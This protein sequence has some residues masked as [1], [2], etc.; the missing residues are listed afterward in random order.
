MTTSTDSP[1][2][3][4][5]VA[6]NHS[7]IQVI[8]HQGSSLN[9]LSLEEATPTQTGWHRLSLSLN[10]TVLEL[11][12][13]GNILFHTLQTEMSYTSIHLGGPDS[14]LSSQLS[15]LPFHDYFIGC[16]TNVTINNND[17]TFDS[18]QQRGVQSGCC[19]A[20]RPLL[21]C[22][23]DY[24]SNLSFRTSPVLTTN[25]E[26]LLVSFQIR[27]HRN[28][29][30]FSIDSESTTLTA[31]LS[32]TTLTLDLISSSQSVTSIDCPGN[33]VE[34]E[35]HTVLLTFE[36]STLSCDIDGARSSV[37][38][39]PSISSL[40]LS[41][42]TFG[43]PN[44]IPEGLTTFGGCVRRLQIN[45]AD[46]SPDLASSTNLEE[47]INYDLVRWREIQFVLN[48]LEVME[49][50][51]VQVTDD[52]IQITL[53]ADIYSDQFASR[54][55]REIQ[56]AIQLRAVDGPSEGYF[57]R[58]DS[59]FRMS[60]FTYY[61]II[62]L[63][64]EKQIMY[65]H[66]GSINMTDTATLEAFVECDGEKD[67][68]FEDSLLIEVDSRNDIPVVSRR[69]R[70][71]IAMGTSRVI[72]PDIITVSDEE[73]KDLD[74]ILYS[75]VGMSSP[76]CGTCEGEKI[77]AVV[78]T[79]SPHLGALLFSQAAI[80]SGNI[81]FQHYPLFRTAKVTINLR[82]SDDLAGSIDTSIE[83]IPYEGHI[84][85]LAEENRC[86]FVKE[87]GFAVL[88]STDLNASTDFED[89]H[90]I[91]TY[92]VIQ[93]VRYGALQK[94]VSYPG[95]VR[96]QWITLERNG[97]FRNGVTLPH[98]FTQDD[99]NN[100][101][102]RYVH[103]NSSQLFLSYDM[104]AYQLRSTNLLGPT[105]N[106]CIDV[107]FN[108]LLLTPDISI[109]IHPIVVNE[110]GHVTIDDQ[111]L[112]TAIDV[113]AAYI[114]D[115]IDTEQLDIVYFLV[116]PPSVGELKL[117]N[118]SLKSGD[119]FTEGD[120]RA[121]YLEYVHS[122]T[123]E[124]VDSFIIFAR[125]VITDDLLLKS[126]N[127]TSEVT[128][129]ITVTPINNHLPSLREGLE[130]IQPAEGGWVTITTSHID[131]TDEDRPGDPLDI[132]LRKPRS[133][134]PEQEPNGHFAFASNPR[135]PIR[136]FTMEQVEN[137]SVIFVH[138]INESARLSFIQRLRIGDGD[139]KHYVRPVSVCV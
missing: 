1:S 34:R 139:N 119:N 38:L 12:V 32:N 19:I 18:A 63:N 101:R 124:H 49:G 4:L 110:G 17:V 16:M 78:R 15:D 8:L 45:K 95:G 120:V 84:T 86:I 35:W 25:N 88:D 132:L 13:D 44:Y 93:G 136:T 47:V 30:V 97:T 43:R 9:T 72:T 80:N 59:K 133:D 56:Q 122:G 82:V 126:P 20:A 52:I 62:S 36:P 129:H 24:L 125:A 71:D 104:F 5:A 67:I 10:G 65:R 90:P 37:T 14:F 106:F 33:V 111:T 92:D 87:G 58:G 28:G 98:S 11:S 96:A 108:D 128:A 66:G 50:E 85:L 21:Y 54:Y 109:E 135:T 131:I 3:Y 118:Q 53:P 29:H 70:M 2:D 138:N 105:G 55:E 116:S 23:E 41:Q 115:P 26:Q 7:Q 27:A 60:D 42:L 75:V 46:L 112:M 68:L 81:S 74:H 69:Q 57:A 6:S 73:T 134:T 31:V 61:D 40:R 127:V 130:A 22:F 121:R 39:Q 102:I 113:E 77:G 123:E 94:W 117:N 89:Q 48:P 137:R 79:H 83:V 100:G 76:P 64:R 99:I 103:H 51:S 107:V 114:L 91:L